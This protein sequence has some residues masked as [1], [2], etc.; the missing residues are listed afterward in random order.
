MK[1]QKNKILGGGGVDRQLS[2]SNNENNFLENFKN[3]KFSK[4][5]QK[6]FCTKQSLQIAKFCA[7]KTTLNTSIYK[8]QSN[9]FYTTAILLA[10]LFVFV[11]CM[12]FANF[13]FKEGILNDLSVQ[14]INISSENE[15]KN[16]SMSGSYTLTQ[17]IVVNN[18]VPYSSTFTGTLDGNGHTITINSYTFSQSSTSGS[19]GLFEKTDGAH[20]LN[21]HVKWVQTLTYNQHSVFYAQLGGIVGTAT[22]TTIENC[23]VEANFQTIVVA[24]GGVIV[25]GIVGSSSGSTI[26]NC[27]HEGEF[28]PT[29]GSDNAQVGGIVGGGN[30][31]ITNCYHYGKISMYCGITYP[32]FTDKNSITNCFSIGIEWGEKESNEV[33]L[34]WSTEIWGG[35]GTDFPYL[36][37]FFEEFSLTYNAGIGVGDDKIY[38]Y[39]ENSNVQLLGNE[40]GFSYG[41]SNFLGWKIK[42]NDTLYNEGDSLTINQNIVLVAQWEIV[43]CNVNFNVNT[44]IGAIF[45][46]CDEDN[47]LTQI[48]VKKADVYNDNNPSFILTLEFGKTYKVIISTYYTTNINF[49]DTSGQAIYE[50]P[51]G[52]ELYK[53]ILTF[54]ASDNLIIRLNINSF[55]GNNGI[56]I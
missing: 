46:L 45:M 42:G 35:L 16:M 14:A 43:E 22:N 47:V 9:S 6:E 44:N 17:D 1:I 11:C 32:I 13:S 7:Q 4:L 37:T 30:S 54:V 3:Q 56:V 18:W 27:A 2:T 36:K 52:Q 23:Y 38:Y 15:L 29:S 33:T 19:S 41:D 24:S 20:I 49:A 55:V 51:D 31:V 8:K 48:F 28:Y 26:T 50:N 39:K 40:F 53:N 25:G 5:N 21:L 10:W 34:N 12:F